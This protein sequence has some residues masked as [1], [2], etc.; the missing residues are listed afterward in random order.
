MTA[1]I[2]RYPFAATSSVAEIFEFVRDPE[3]RPNLINIALIKR[4]GIASNNESKVVETLRFLTA[5]DSTGT[6]TNA[7]E[8]LKRNFADG[9]GVAIRAAYGDLFQTIPQKLM[10]RER[11]VS[12]FRE[13]GQAPTNQRPE[14][15]ARLFVWLCDQAGIAIPASTRP[16][17]E[18]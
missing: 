2:K 7:F 11:L 18:T 8:E 6:P 15:S 14:R 12:F 17:A 1:A 16:M 5:I 9:L 4:L 3:W 10:T 13:K